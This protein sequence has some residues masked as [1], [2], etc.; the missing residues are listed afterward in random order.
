[1][2]FHIHPQTDERDTLALQ[3]KSLLCTFDPGKQN[4]AANADNPLPGKQ[5]TGALQRPDNL[6]R[7]AGKT[8]GIGHIAVSCDL[9]PR[10]PANSSTDPREHAV[11]GGC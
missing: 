5:A 8:S 10:D 11:I 4:L 2:L 6:P 3:Q 1:V 7:R 9:A